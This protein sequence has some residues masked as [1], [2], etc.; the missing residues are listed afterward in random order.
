MSAPV[1]LAD[2][3]PAQR[4]LVLALVNAAAKKPVRVSETARTGQED[5]DDRRDQPPAA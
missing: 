5:R 3:T 1:R 4:R 2:L